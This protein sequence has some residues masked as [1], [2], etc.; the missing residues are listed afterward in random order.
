MHIVG[1][2]TTSPKSK[3][4]F[5]NKL[6]LGW[7]LMQKTEFQHDS[8]LYIATRDL[9]EPLQEQYQKGYRYIIGG[10]VYS[11]FSETMGN[12]GDL[13][14]NLPEGNFWFL[15]LSPD[16]SE[17]DLGVDRF[18]MTSLYFRIFNNSFFF[19]TDLRDIRDIVGVP[20][21]LDDIGIVSFFI[22]G[23][24][25]PPRTIYK[26]IS[27]IPAASYV[28]IRLPNQANFMEWHVEEAISPLRRYWAPKKEQQTGNPKQVA[29]RLF[30]SLLEAVDKRAADMNAISLSGGL[31]SSLTLDLLSK[32]R[33]PEQII[34]ITGAIK[35]VKPHEADFVAAP[36]VAQTY[37]IR[38]ETVLL[39]PSDPKVV[40]FWRAATQDWI[41]G[42]HI[43]S[44]LWYA[45]A[46]KLGTV[47]EPSTPV[48]TAETA[49]TLAEFTFT[50]PSRTAYVNR[51]L[52]SPQLLSFIDRVPSSI[53]RTVRKLASADARDPFV[54]DIVKSWLRALCDR[55]EYFA[56]LLFGYGQLPGVQANALAGRLAIIAPGFDRF[57]R[58]AQENL[59]T[60]YFLDV[61][62]K[63]LQYSFL[64]WKLDI[65]CQGQDVKIVI[66][67]SQHYKLSPRFPF[68]DTKVVNIFATLP[69][70]ARRFYKHPKHFIQ[71][72]AKQYSSIPDFVLTRGRLTLRDITRP[73]K[74]S[75]NAFLCNLLKGP[76]R[77]YFHKLLTQPSFLDL[78]NPEVIN[79]PLLQRQLR[80]F[81]YGES[82]VDF[83]L[84]YKCA[85]LEEFISG[86]RSFGKIGGGK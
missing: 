23:Y 2:V 50:G 67:S 34:A 78:L 37:G 14:L 57:R 44:V 39:D 86:Q 60:P 83:G 65:F 32:V 36:K 30:T 45:M 43:G 15:R 24:P 29:K 76:L 52:Y 81:H 80:K 41:T 54:W 69:P 8:P 7:A 61:S 68:L 47:V 19:S 49:D 31:D 63:D 48:F 3:D 70:S 53:K 12:S 25:P 46:H 33:K 79:I 10:K 16:G 64:C 13:D 77:E 4:S 11:S 42:I 27:M 20:Q 5:I 51:F 6:G 74:D 56:G 40:E 73:P 18:G 55:R 66:N 62:P 72:I 75:D 1:I 35:G 85:S 38:H 82:G 28:T 84:V 17:I 71:D 58:W 59:I 26:H 22:W 21:T 9:K